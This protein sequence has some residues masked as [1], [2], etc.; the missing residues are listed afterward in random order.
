MKEYFGPVELVLITVAILAA[1]YLL[2]ILT[3]KKSQ[4]K[5]KNL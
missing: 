1:C 4:N 5:R 3:E 2:A